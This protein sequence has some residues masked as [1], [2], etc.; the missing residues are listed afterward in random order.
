[1]KKL[2]VKEAKLKAYLTKGNATFVWANI[3]GVSVLLFAMFVIA[4]TISKEQ[5]NITITIGVVIATAL[6]ML[7]FVGATIIDLLV[8]IKASIYTYSK[9]KDAEV[10]Q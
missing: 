6:G 5:I 8:S 9:T 2:T 4:F 10:R 1:M 7:L 3:I